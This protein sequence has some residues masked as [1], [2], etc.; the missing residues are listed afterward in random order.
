[1][2]HRRVVTLASVLALLAACGPTE[3]VTAEYQRQRTDIVGGSVAN[4]DPAVVALA[5]LYGSEYLEYCTGT[6]IGP[7]TV[8]TAA[9]C[10]FPYGE[11]A[12][13]FV[14]FGTYVASPSFAVPIT[15]FIPHPMYSRQRSVNDIA[16]VK[17][18]TAVTAVSPIGI[19][20]TPLDNTW[21]GKSIRHVGFGNTSVTNGNATGSGTK[22]EVIYGIREILQEV[23]ES[24]TRGK[25][26]CTGD[27]GGPGFITHPG[28]TT[29]VVAGV[30][31]FGDADCTVQGYDANVATYATWVLNT[32]SAW[33]GP[34]CIEDTRCKQGCTPVDPDCACIEDNVCNP[35]CYNLD[36][37][38]DC[39]KNC[40]ADGICAVGICPTPDADCVDEGQVCQR[41]EQCL[42][43]ACVGDPQHPDTYC[44]KPC[45]SDPECTVDGMECANGYCQYAQRPVAN[46]GEPC[47]PDTLCMY[48][49]CAGTTL[50]ALR[51]RVPC[52]GP[53]TCPGTTQT[54]IEG[55][56]GE[57]YC[58]EANE[59]Q[60]QNPSENVNPNVALPIGTQSGSPK[61]TGGCS[62][63]AGGPWWLALM[64]LGGLVLR[65]RRVRRA[66]A[67]GAVGSFLAL[68]GCGPT[69]QDAPVSSELT[70]EAKEI[71]GG[72][73]N[74]GDPEVFMLM[75]HYDDGTGSSCTATLI[76]KSTLLTAA[77]CVDPRLAE[78][79]S[80]RIWAVNR[81]NA[82]EAPQSEWIE[83]DE[84]KIHPGW[85]PF[86]SN[87]GNDIAMARLER[88]PGITPKAWNTSSVDGLR[89]KPLRAV[90]Y[91][92]TSNANQGS[93]G[94][95]R[96]VNLVFD[97]IDST[98]IFLGDW[99]GKGVCH[100]DSGGPT[101]HTF[102]DG[103]ERVVGVHSYDASGDCV[104]GGDIRVD[105]Y[106]D[107]VQ[108]WLDTWEEPSCAEDGRCK[109]TGCA[110]F[111]VDCY[112]VADGACTAD[113]R[114]LSTDPDCPANCAADGVCAESTCP[115]PDE[116]CVLDGESCTSEEQCQSRI[117]MSDPQHP[118]FYCSRPCATTPQ[119]PAGM[120][121]VP[122]AQVC[123]FVQVIEAGK[124][125]AC[126]PGESRCAQ[127]TVCTG[128]TS[129]TAHCE[130]PCTTATEC[131]AQNTCAI[132][133]DGTTKYCRAPEATPVVLPTGNNVAAKPGTGCAAVGGVPMSALVLALAGVL[134]RRKR[135]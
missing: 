103:I 119:C 32:M 46:I 47:T 99:S 77:H 5:V 113:C 133:H 16:V 17:L 68:G 115:V 89:Q 26:T 4:G 88:S 82:M 110:T 42:W 45:S 111:D 127:G 87:L 98:H 1:M 73:V 83:I 65:G 53:G 93:S 31:S 55:A 56:T 6:L 51:C 50:Q 128:A 67:A 134:S 12:R 54:C 40:A 117:C 84:T 96:H 94:I 135:S 25:Q 22:R 129:A 78:A 39:P 108:Q 124:G 64:A 13:Y 21:L 43:R 8:L 19:N 35:Q 120:E 118:D 95:K 74:N 3:D 38:P 102:P 61:A 75:M 63:S 106:Q 125:E 37:D 112:C 97:R 49:V 71:V 109:A 29:E 2:F 130:V 52:T 7:R 121:C 80:V 132:G 20:L 9:H 92:I 90:G 60:P 66:V 91:G 11:Q 14:V 33:D 34:S 122:G 69:G 116:D 86:G 48:S 105:A 72:S 123:Q 44:S 18:A 41:E 76:G 23:I 70:T 107:F 57:L 100:G 36:K 28:S 81:T 10:D 79:D 85:N 62:S 131:P 101:F 30:V 59:L 58:A 126:T 104:Y 15:D 27:S 114:D 24:G